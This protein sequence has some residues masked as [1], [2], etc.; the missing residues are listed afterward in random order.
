MASFDV[1]SEIDMQEVR[2]AVDQAAREV[3]TR[4]DFKDTGSQ[5]ALSDAQ[6][7]LLSSSE[8]R[9]NALRQVLEEKLVKRKVSLKALDYGEVEDASG[10]SVRQ[11]ALLQAGISGEKAKELNKFIKG[12]GIKGVQSQ[13]QGEQVRVISKKRDHLQ[14]V[15]SKMKETDFD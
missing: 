1:V 15:I 11:V 13:T 10:T 9:L 5:V 14:T 6:I 2:N 12:L 7:S 3:S 4:Y 8:D